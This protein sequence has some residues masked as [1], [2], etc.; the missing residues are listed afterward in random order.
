M[1][2]GDASINQS[3]HLPAEG[4]GRRRCCYTRVD[5]TRWKHGI[6]EGRWGGLWRCRAE[7]GTSAP[8]RSAPKGSKWLLSS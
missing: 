5:M 8:K 2:G 6:H 7:L 3:S 1:A 4:R